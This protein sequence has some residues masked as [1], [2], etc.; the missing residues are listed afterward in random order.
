MAEDVFPPA[1]RRMSVL[2]TMIR[3]SATGPAAVHVK[4]RRGVIDKPI[5]HVRLDAQLPHPRDDQDAVPGTG[6][7]GAV[8]QLAGDDQLKLIAVS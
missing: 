5:R 3:R 6:E 1:V 4:V 8:K 7:L 2:S